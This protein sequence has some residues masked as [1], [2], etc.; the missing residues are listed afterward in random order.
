[1]QPA[2]R[3]NLADNAINNIRVEITAN[4]WQIGDRI[5]NEA[6]LAEMLGVSRGTVREAVRVLVAQGFL[7]TRQ[8]SGT[9][10]RSVI[11]ADD[12]LLRIRR[13]GLRDQVE[14]RCALEVEAARLAAL[15][16]TPAIIAGLRQLLA[17]RGEYDTANHDRYVERDLAFHKAVVAASG[18]RAFVEVYEFFSASIQEVIKAT[19]TGELPEPDMAAHVS[20]VDAIASGDPDMAASTTR[21]F[22]A[23]ILI[24]LDRLLAS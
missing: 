6:T 7:E 5:P 3:S 14:T 18:N 11:D 13:T 16:H 17:A 15:R 8:G 24:E 23:P 1:M 2:A 20:I 22:M 4:R 9:Y 19:V 21:A 10:V 12:T